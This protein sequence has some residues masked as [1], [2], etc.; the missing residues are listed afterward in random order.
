MN[1]DQFFYYSSN[2]KIPTGS[3]V[4]ISLGRRKTQG[5]VLE[6]KPEFKRSGSYKLKKIEKVIKEDF[7]TKNQIKLAK[8]IS[9]YYICSLGITIKSFVP[10]ISGTREKKKDKKE[11]ISEKREITLTP[12]QKS[13]IASICKNGSKFLLHGPSSSGKTEV[14]A[15]SAKKV[16]KRS[17]QALIL[18]PELTIIPQAIEIYQK[19]FGRNNVVEM[20]SKI[21]KGKFYKNWEKI[22]SGEAKIIIGTRQSL[23]LPFKSL[24]LIVIDEEH[25]IAFKQWDMNPRYDARRVAEELTEIHKSKIILGSATPRTESYYNALQEDYQLLKLSKLQSEKYSSR[26]EI[27]D[28][29]KERWNKSPSSKLSSI[30]KTLKAEIEFALKYRRQIILFLN[31]Q[32]MSAFSVC[33]NCKTF[34]ACPKCERALVAQSGGDFQCLHCSYKSSIFPSCSKCK[35]I[36]F[37]NIGIGTQKIEKEIQSFFPGAKIK[38]IDT[39]EMKKSAKSQDKFWKEFSTGK[40]DIVIGTQMITKSFDLPNVGLIGIIDADSLLHIP[41]FL[42]NEKAFGSIYQAT[43]R[44]GRTGSEF[45]GKSI[46]QTFHPEN[47]IIKMVANL[48]YKGFFAH[49]IEERKALNYPPFTHIIKLFFQDTDAKNVSF[50]TGKLHIQIEKLKLSNIKIYPPQEMLLSN[51][52]GRYRR[53]IILKAKDYPKLPTRLKTI[54]K[55]LGSGWTIDVDPLSIN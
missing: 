1:R 25:D 9:D 48:D 55:S 35:G 32:G 4:E 46:I 41:D 51:I 14:Y 6:S 24:K 5:I 54:L 52:R 53:Q 10:K 7:L 22:K 28:M 47:L 15:Q 30:S 34:L 38:R 11:N 50:E 12:E 36:N 8:F 17:G 49:E 13:A 2:K 19:V 20:H 45:T 37:R 16:I 31:R 3:L 40:I 29:K 21:A 18:L 42:T 27:V 44:T 43:G 39:Q 26:I 23:F 33:E